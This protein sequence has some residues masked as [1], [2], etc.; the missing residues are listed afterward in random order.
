MAS[1]ST[2]PA[3]RAR[4]NPG[5]RERVRSPREVQELRDEIQA[6]KVEMQQVK[7]QMEA[8]STTFGDNVK[9]EFEKTEKRFN[10][11]QVNGTARFRELEKKCG[12]KLAAVMRG[13]VNLG[14]QVR[15]NAA[16]PPP[17]PTW[18]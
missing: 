9:Q 16:G 12:E 14:N 2:N 15:N 13:L 11:F 4:S 6:V 18:P 8:W 1:P 3:Q 17:A 7:Q 5:D 10:D